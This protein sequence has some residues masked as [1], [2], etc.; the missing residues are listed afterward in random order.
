VVGV[1]KLGCHK[2][3]LALADTTVNGGFDAFANFLL[4]TIVAGTAAR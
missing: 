1:P 4:V 2:D 3:V